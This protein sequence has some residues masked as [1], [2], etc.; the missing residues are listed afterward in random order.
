MLKSVL[1]V[2]PSLRANSA[3]W[4]QQ[5]VSTVSV[6]STQNLRRNKQLFLHS[7]AFPA[8]ISQSIDEIDPSAP[9]SE[10]PLVGGQAVM[11]GVMMRNGDVYGLAV[12]RQ[13]GSVVAC[14]RPWRTFFSSPFFKIPFVRGF[15]VLLETLANGIG[16]LNRP[17]VLAEAEENEQL[18]RWQLVLSMII[19]VVMACALFLLAPHFLSLLMFWL[20]AG[21]NVEGLSFHLW[22]GFYKVCIF[23]GYLWL[24]SLLPEIQRVLCYHGA[25]H[26]TIHAFEQADEVSVSTVLPMSRLHPRCGTT[27]LLF[28][29]T[30]SIILHAVCVPLLLMLVHPAG[31]LSK[32]ALSLLF[33]LMLIIP[34][35]TLSYELIRFAATLQGGLKA[36]LLQAPGLVLQ[37]LTTKEPDASQVEV[38]VASLHVALD[39]EDRHVVDAC[40]YDLEES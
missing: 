30:I 33:K 1:P 24:I 10:R 34:I 38:A 3:S 37:R 13:D 18:S 15:P 22:D 2:I 23:M 6:K 8:L 12:R 27:F 11:E 32:H 21:G 25:E 7:L 35:S 39:P 26:K 14:R 28:V 29:I 36:R 20:N 31:E 9:A 16:A 40:D 4:T 5:D 17:A 19:A